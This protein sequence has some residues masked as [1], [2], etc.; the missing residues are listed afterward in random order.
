MTMSN[1]YKHA[2]ILALYT[3]ITLV[4]TWPVGARLTTHLAGS[5]GDPWQTMW[6]FDHKLSLWQFSISSSQFSNFL[7]DEFLGGGEPQLV[8]NS[9]WPWMPLHALFRQ[10]TAYNLVWLLSF[11]LSGYAMYLLVRS[12]VSSDVKFTIGNLQL[13]IAPFIAGVGYMFLPFHVA[14]SYGHFGAMQMQWIP[15]II[16][17]TI[18]AFRKPSA[19]KAAGLGLLFLVQ[20]WTEHHYFLWMFILA[21]IAGVYFRKEISR[22]VRSVPKVLIT[23]YSLLVTFFILVIVLSYLPTIRLALQ[24]T[25][26]L[27]LGRD[28]LIRFSADVFAPVVPAPFHTVWGAISN[29]LFFRYFTG[30]VSEATQFLGVMPLLLIIFFHQKLPAR[31]TKFWFWVAGIFFLMSLGPRLHVFGNV[32][33]IPLPY[34]LLDSWPVISSVRAVARAGSMVGLSVMVLLG[35]VLASQ[36]KRAAMGIAVLAIILLEFLFLPVPTQSAQLHPIYTALADMPGSKLLEIP[37]ATN[38]TI[39]SRALYASRIHGKE[40][41]GNIALE[42]AQ[43]P[44]AFEIARSAPALRQLLYLRT[45]T[46]QLSRDE[47]F[48]QDMAETFPDVMRWLDAHAVLIHTDS[49]SEVQLTAARQFLEEQV[50][51]KPQVH[52]DVVLYDVS[53]SGVAPH[54]GVFLVRGDGWQN[55][56]FDAE[57]ASTFAE[58]T[59]RADASLVNLNA[60]VVQV[61]LTFTVPDESRGAGRIIFADQHV[62]DIPVGPN[63]VQVTVQ[64]PAGEHE[65]VFEVTGPEKIII[66]NPKLEA[67]RN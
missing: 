9:V 48:G 14:H 60:D 26:P 47:F 40:V 32:T 34:E 67:N 35:L 16:A 8:N 36:L 54:D 62:A 27:N 61:T 64:V 20:A 53:T 41:I 46:L 56:A 13:E 28:Q 17:L 33:P 58:V 37:A 50:K 5:G 29:S 19:W 39:A 65:L 23:R 10:P 51:A 55:V 38:Y 11:I 6:R 15:F 66:Q 2:L 30:N 12:L 63:S 52:S 57:R 42:R 22:K 44:E 3:V 24:D 21:I 1:L 4:M 43:D 49:L 18:S 59:D 25:S 31:L 45:N 7:V